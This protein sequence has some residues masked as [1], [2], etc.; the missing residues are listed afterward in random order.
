MCLAASGGSLQQWLTAEIVPCFPQVLQ[1][2]TD[3]EVLL[4]IPSAAASLLG[5]DEESRENQN[6]FAKKKKRMLSS[7]ISFFSGCTPIKEEFN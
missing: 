1:D 3:Q 7:N 2:I 6:P 4:K 5:R